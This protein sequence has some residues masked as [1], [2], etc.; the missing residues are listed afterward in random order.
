[1]S[2]VTAM[3]FL[4][5]NI[6]A[7]RL[8]FVG[9]DGSMGLTRGAVYDV[10]IRIRKNWIWVSWIPIGPYQT[11]GDPPRCCPYETTQA[12]ALNWETLKKGEV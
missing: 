10:E 5:R 2:G 12:F 9:E 1:M 11:S 8:R 7:S 4:K 6:G 3:V